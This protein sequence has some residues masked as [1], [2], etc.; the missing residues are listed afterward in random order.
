MRIVEELGA[1]SLY[2][3]FTAMLSRR[4][5]NTHMCVFGTASNARQEIFAYVH[6]C[7]RVVVQSVA[8]HTFADMLS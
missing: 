2:G 8:Q 5:L 1:K 4:R 3:S 6:A 7:S